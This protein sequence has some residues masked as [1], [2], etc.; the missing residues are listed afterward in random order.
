MS[1]IYLLHH[2]QVITATL[3][4]VWSFFSD[5]RNL[6]V[7]TPPALNLKIINDVYG[8]EIYAGQI[9]QYKVKPLFGIGLPWLTEIT[10]VKWRDYFVDEQ[11]RGPYKFWHHQHHFKEVSGGVLMTDLVHYQ[12]PFGYAGAIAA[13]IVRRKVAEI[14][15]YRQQRI[16]AFWPGAAK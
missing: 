9:M 1:K 14:F 5:A 7:I 11:R 12:L 6:A 16:A 4:E 8:R 13:S 3:D 15:T 2:E 10:H